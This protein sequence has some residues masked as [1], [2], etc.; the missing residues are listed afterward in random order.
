MPLINIHY[1]KDEEFKRERVED[2]FRD[3][4]KHVLGVDENLVV[5]FFQ[6]DLLGQNGLMVE[7]EF[8]KRPKTVVDAYVASIRDQ[9]PEIKK[10]SVKMFEEDMTYFYQ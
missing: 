8:K 3:V 2:I 10:V 5:I 1:S 9:L 4:T 7:V 6:E